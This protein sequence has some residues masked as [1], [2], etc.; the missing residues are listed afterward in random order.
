MLLGTLHED[1]NQPYEQTKSNISKKLNSKAAEQF[2]V[3]FRLRERSIFID[4]FYG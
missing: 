3:N 4:Q 2:W 1:L